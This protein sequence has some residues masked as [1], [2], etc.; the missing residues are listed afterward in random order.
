MRKLAALLGK[1]GAVIVARY[2]DGDYLVS[3]EHLICRVPAGALPAVLAR[4]PELLATVLSGPAD[5]YRYESSGVKTWEPARVVEI[6]ERTQPS[7][8]GRVTKVAV[9]E[10]SRSGLAV[11]QAILRSDS[12]EV[13]WINAEFLAAA[14][15]SAGAEVQMGSR[16]DLVRA[17]TYVFAPFHP[18]DAD[19]RAAAEGLMAAGLS[20]SSDP[21]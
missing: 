14:E 7:H 10:Q 21:T 11:Y 9:L 1:A 2:H 16:R 8:V 20:E 15:I 18:A 5:A 19:T 4:R 17:G 3:E 13:V 6:Y 12:R